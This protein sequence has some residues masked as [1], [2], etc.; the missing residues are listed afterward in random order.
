MTLP[1]LFLSAPFF[2]G[3]FTGAGLIMAIGAQ[4]AF[5]LTQGLRRQHHWSIAGLCSLIDAVLIV[6]GVAG[7]GVLISQSP[8]FLNLATWGGALFL[9]WYG[10]NALRSAFKDQ[11]L[12]TQE[13]KVSS[14]STAL[15]TTLALSLLNPHVYLD[16][17]VLLGSIGGHYPSDQRFW[18]A[19]GAVLASFCWFFSLSL[20]SR[21]LIPLF[22]KPIAWRILDGIVC[23]IMW[24]LAANL[25]RNALL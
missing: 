19:A 25:I 18:F 9:L 7:M 1:A 13:S 22:Q 4:N 15:L 12:Q 16:T 21:W 2:K 14:L 20:G 10:S 17:V 8:L 11:T 3:L 24:G 23:L 5:V 6:L